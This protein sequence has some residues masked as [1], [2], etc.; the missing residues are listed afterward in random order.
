VNNKRTQNGTI[1]YGSCVLTWLS[2]L[3]L[4]ALTVTVGGMRLGGISIATALV[5]AAVKSSL[6]LNIFMHLKHE[7]SFFKITMLIV[8]VA[9]AIFIGLT[10]VDILFR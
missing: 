1:G 8:I 4:T 2:L 10:F 6:V 9:I 3:A 7:K 5:I